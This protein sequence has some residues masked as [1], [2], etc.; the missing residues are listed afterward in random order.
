MFHLPLHS[1]GS[2]DPEGPVGAVSVRLV[3][4]DKAAPGNRSLPVANDDIIVSEEPLS[5]W[6]GRHLKSDGENIA[7][8]NEM[9][10]EPRRR[11]T[12]RTKTASFSRAASPPADPRQPGDES[13][14][15]KI[16]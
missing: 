12:A 15:V 16:S 2:C 5:L 14:P 3:L 8:Q 11:N 10:G 1:S 4:G 7:L 13:R 9:K 6:D